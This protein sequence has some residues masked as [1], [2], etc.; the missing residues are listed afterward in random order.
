MDPGPGPPARGPGL[1]PPISY[2][3]GSQAHV[4]EF[5]K[6]LLETCGRDRQE[7]CYKG[8]KQAAIENAIEKVNGGQGGGNVEYN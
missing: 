1:R 4:D 8:V 7:P 5:T 2:V 3:S 6:G